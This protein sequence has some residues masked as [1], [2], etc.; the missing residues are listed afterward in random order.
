MFSPRKKHEESFEI[1]SHQFQ[2]PCIV[3][4]FLCV[5]LQPERLTTSLRRH[6]VA[7]PLEHELGSSHG[8]TAPKALLVPVEVP[9]L[10]EA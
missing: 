5:C 6:R 9:P 4:V 2:A 1:S 10:E 7:R 8:D 3:M